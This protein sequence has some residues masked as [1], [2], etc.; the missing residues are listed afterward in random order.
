MNEE[1]ATP[2]EHHICR[3]YLN[4]SAKARIETAKAN[5]NASDKRNRH[6]SPSKVAASEQRT[7]SRWSGTA[8]A[9]IELRSAST[10]TAARSL[11]TIK[12][13]QTR[14]REIKT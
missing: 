10:Q 5:K 6:W 2:K 8:I 13:N 12:Q 9:L 3:E 7:D 4:I 14:S 1:T 11:D